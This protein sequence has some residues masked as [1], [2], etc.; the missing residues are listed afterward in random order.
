MA[1][2]VFSQLYAVGD[3]MSDSGGIYQLTSQVL[4]LAAA[5]GFNIEGLQPI[6][7]TPPY[8][9]KF[10]NG[11]VLPEI[12][13]QLLGANLVNFSLGGAE[14]LGT[15][16][17]AQAAGP[18]AAQLA[19]LP[20]DPALEAILNKNI[21]LSGQIADLV[22]ET[23]A[24]PPPANS[25]LVSMI[26]LNDFQ[27]LIGPEPIDPQTLIGK[28]AQVAA[29]II[30]AD[31][32]LAHTAYN[33]GIGTVIFETL[34][35]PSFFPV[36]S[37]LSAEQQAI[38][39]AAVDVVNLGLKADALELRLEGHDARVVDLAR[40]ADEISA[41]PGTFGFQKLD[42][43][44]LMPT[45]GDPTAVPFGQFKFNDAAPPI[46]QTAFFDPLHA[47]TKLHGVLA[48]FAAAS[49]TDHTDFRGA[50]NDFIIGTPSDDLVLAGA[51]ND[52]AFLGG[53][54]DVAFGG[55]GDDAL[56][57]GAGNDILAGGAGNDRLTGGLGADVLA[58]GAGNNRL[59]GGA[60][61]DA[62]IA[63]LGNDTAFGGTGDDLF[64]Y[65]EPQLLGGSSTSDHFDGGTGFN[66]LALRLDPATQAAELADVAANFHPGQPFKFSGMDLK[67]TNIQQIVFA[68]Q[69]NFSDVPS[70]SADLGAQLQKA[71]LFGLV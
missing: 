31:L 24:H 43:P 71:D 22:A 23:S 51:G 28:A 48:A 65:T 7:V 62:I 32:D 67:I 61:N 17:L 69:A 9:G 57:G 41:D 59:D 49:L 4:S 45:S 6:P 15:L 2:P 64:L 34:P 33:Q 46:D 35:A 52:V 20:P 30:Q 42:Q 68:T 13:A 58:G 25:A 18:L 1:T 21:N 66:T 19:E 44:T 54:N 8:A 40:M 12:T 37:A 26:G 56:D 14:A 29:G 27:S 63:G 50:G 38:G 16:T 10:S 60:G 55:L 11:R 70:P 5:D 36:G 3:S 53:G 47:T 39:D